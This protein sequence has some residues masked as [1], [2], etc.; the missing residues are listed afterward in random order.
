[1]HI[2]ESEEDEDYKLAMSICKVVGCLI[3]DYSDCVVDNLED[4]GIELIRLAL[5]CTS[6]KERELSLLM[7]DLWYILSFWIESNVEDFSKYS[8][9][10][11]FVS[12]YS[13]LLKILLAQSMYESD[14]LTWDEG[15]FPS[16][17]PSSLPLPLF[18]RNQF[19]IPPAG[20]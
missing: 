2:I 17:L 3:E 15:N 5:M 14:A 9:R 6:H 11:I 19:F 16:S 18:F 10:N 20:C 4:G 13:E 7:L 12:A 1:M 8:K